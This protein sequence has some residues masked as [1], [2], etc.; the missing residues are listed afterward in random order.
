MRRN[1]KKK[2]AGG[3]GWNGKALTGRQG[4][5][6]ALVILAMAADAGAQGRLAGSHLG[7]P[8]SGSMAGRKIVISIPDRKLALIKGGRVVLLF[9][10]A[11]GARRTPSPAGEFRVVNR[12]TNPTYYHPGEVIPPG[13]E[14]PV[15]PRWI[16]LSAKGYGI[17]GTNEP[18]LI[19]GRVS[20]GC[21][22]MR[23]RDVKI[24]FA[25]VR[26]GERVEL[27]SRRDAETARFFPGT[28]ARVLVASSAAAQP[29]MAADGDTR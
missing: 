18:R 21:I 1:W 10:V 6:L 24:L 7:A 20:H 2:A 25:H 15:G 17:H 27:H 8:S 3:T 5:I 22:R 19:G 11:V 14:N 23:N 26:V 16:G 29:V 9:P 28:Q 4:G 12:V 13:P